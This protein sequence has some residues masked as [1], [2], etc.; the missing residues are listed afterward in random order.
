VR[1]PPNNRMNPTGPIGP[2]CIGAFA[3]VVG[4]AA[5]WVLH[6]PARRVM[7]EALGNADLTARLVCMR[8]MLNVEKAL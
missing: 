5:E 3:F 4:L 2:R 6:G 7:R 1:K 8:R